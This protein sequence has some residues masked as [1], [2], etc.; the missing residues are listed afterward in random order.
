M[1]Y[2]VIS[3]MIPLVFFILSYTLA[4]EHI[5]K[6]SQ[7]TAV[8]AKQAVAGDK[9]TA[10]KNKS[11]SPAKSEKKQKGGNK[12]VFRLFAVLFAEVG[13]LN[14][15]N[16]VIRYL[17]FN[18][19]SGIPAA[20]VVIVS[21]LPYAAVIAPYCTK[22]ESWH[23]FLKWSAVSAAAV[24]VAEVAVFNG[25]SITKDS[26]DI[27]YT[28]EN[29]R[30][31]GAVTTAPDALRFTSD[32][33]LYIDDLPDDVHGVVLKVHQDERFDD[34]VESRPYRCT[35]SFT[36][37]NFKDNY[38]V[39]QTKYLMS[40]DRDCDFTI[41]P[42]GDLKSLRISFNDMAN[43]VTVSEVRVLSAIPFAFSNIRFYLLLIVFIAAVAIKQFRLYKVTYNSRK[44]LHILIAELVAIICTLTAIMFIKPE[45][46][47]W[48]YDPDFK[49]TANPYI[50]TLDAF[51]HHQVS[52]DYGV[53]PRFEE[54][55]DK[56]NWNSRTN[57][58]AFYLWDY[59]YHDG[60]YYT[61]FGVTP[62]LTLY[63]PFYKITGKLPPLSIANVIFGAL[64]IFMFCQMLL[65]AV[66]LFAPRANMLLL[67]LAMPAGVSCLGVHYI[68]NYAD[69]YC[70][71]LGAGMTFLFLCLWLSFKACASRHKIARLIMLFIAGASLALAVGARPGMALSSAIL[72]P[73]FIGILLNKKEKL[74]YRLTQG[75][76]FVLPLLAGGIG[77]MWYNNARFGS[78]FDFGAKYQ[79]TVS[80]VSANKV[81][82]SSF[83]A[84]LYHYFFM[85]TRPRSTFPFVEMQAFGLDNYSQYTYVDFALSVFV[86]PMIVLGV[87]LI[88]YVFK[89]KHSPSIHG[90][91][92]L[93]NNAFYVICFAMAL[94]IGWQDFCLGGIIHR[95]V[96]DIMPLMT[97]GTTLVLLRVLHAPEKKRYLYTAAIAAMVISFAL[98][99]LIALTN[100]TGTIHLHNPNLLEDLENNLIFWR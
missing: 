40:F 77:I 20:A 26:T 64:A 8:P 43:A 99:W 7:K 80:N 75:V 29:I 85:G 23:R 59:A 89:K 67:L 1:F 10:D 61:Y 88:P 76:C 28:P 95:Y 35:A 42:Y 27:V 100:R 6:K 44:P 18:G 38:M 25:K 81:R 56:Y 62:T 22:N 73:L 71:P 97:L 53:D 92:A 9:K 32:G 94:F 70:L 63:Y 84:M 31:E 65:A 79:L 24:L 66:K 87:L 96:I 57:S 30:A 21:L 15:L 12:I 54:L 55:E 37:D 83:P 45:Q 98:S 13:I 36:D 17:T 68:M 34:Y 46:E 4:N 60:K 47:F 49:Q 2:F 33:S 58:G 14:L 69:M 41:N 39:A 93:Q 91:T 50:M 78:P 3:V 86:F 90:T 72:F 82:L 16:A 48:E 52:L 19:G 51:E 11:G 5:I 74:W